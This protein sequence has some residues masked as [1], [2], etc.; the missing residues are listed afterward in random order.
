M[1]SLCQK[2]QI[3]IIRF[4]IQASIH[5][6]YKMGLQMYEIQYLKEGFSNRIGIDRK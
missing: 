2:E 1:H 6:S 3:Y 5:W 4:S